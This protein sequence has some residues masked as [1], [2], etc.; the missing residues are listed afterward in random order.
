MK[1]NPKEIDYNLD[2]VLNFEVASRDILASVLCLQGSSVYVM[3]V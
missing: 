3:C 1:I 2:I